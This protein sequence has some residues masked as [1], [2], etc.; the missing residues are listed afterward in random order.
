MPWP[1][2][3]FPK[4]L[5]FLQ[6]FLRPCLPLQCCHLLISLW[7]FQ[8]SAQTAAFKCSSHG[9]VAGA[10]GHRRLCIRLFLPSPPP[11]NSTLFLGCEE[12]MFLTIPSFEPLYLV[13][14][15]FSLHV[16]SMSRYMTSPGLRLSLMFDLKQNFRY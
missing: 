11:M 8:W 1:G 9:F 2:K 13:R 3:P 12:R 16:F 7:L 6:K 10:S 5:F 14:V 15:Y 4:H